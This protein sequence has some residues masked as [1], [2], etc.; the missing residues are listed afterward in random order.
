MTFV[1]YAQNCEDVILR[2]VFK[3]KAVGFYID[4][5]ACWPDVASVTKVFY[6]NGWR[7]INIEPHPRVFSVLQEQR[8]EDINLR[9][10]VSSKA[11]T[12]ML[13]EGQSEGE[14]SILNGV[15]GRRFEVDLWTLRQV[16]EKYVTG[17][18]DFL[19]I[20]VEGAELE[21]LQGADLV[22]F[23]PRVIVCEVT[24]PWSNVK[25]I[26]AGEVDILLSAHGYRHVHFDGLNSYY[27]TEDDSELLQ[28][29]WFQPNIIDRYVTAGEAQL[30]TQ[31]TALQAETHRLGTEHAA[32][33]A[34]LNTQLAALQAEMRRLGTEHA[35]CE[36]QLNIQL[37]ALQAETHRLGTEHADREAQLNTQLTALQTETHRLGTEHAAREAQLNTQLAALQ[38]ETHRL[39]TEHA[40]GEAELNTRLTTNL[41]ELARLHRVISEQNTWGQASVRH[42][43]LLN[44]EIAALHNSTSWRIT[45]PFRSVKFAIKR[46]RTIL[47]R[48]PRAVVRRVA[49]LARRR[50]PRLYFKLSTTRAL[51]TVYKRFARSVGAVSSPAPT[52]VKRR[53]P[54]APSAPLQAPTNTTDSLLPGTQADLL[55]EMSQWLTAKRV[56]A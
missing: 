31:L 8:P 32:R 39:G 41:N 21:V 36:A 30:N 16:C 29:P 27:A 24:K 42:V 14:S 35:A 54:G 55:T 5:G 9:I 51:H 46:C 48:A 6:D 18:I 28:G 52:A 47:V 56:H 33:E 2:R 50:A 53:V 20:D 15:G 43:S 25:S 23:R 13:Y 3:N 44:S 38:A 49:R 22:N 34:Q 12:A 4:V 10:A 19:K 45:R 7:G 1:S 37:A 17:T 11:G 40:A 26:Q